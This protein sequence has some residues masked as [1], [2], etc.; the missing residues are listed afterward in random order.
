MARAARQ[1]ELAGVFAS[2]I[3]PRR[4]DSQDPDFSGLLDLLDF[5]AAGGA[6]AICVFSATGEFIDY[7]F[8]ERQRLVHLAVKRS[9]VPLI[10]DV[11][12]STLAG[13]LQLADEA[14]ASGADGLIVMP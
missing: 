5:L 11:S 8:A 14:I 7:S 9:R 10:A 1:L 13:A 3:T 6:K 2:A 12:H 4:K